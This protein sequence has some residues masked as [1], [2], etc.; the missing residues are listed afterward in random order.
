MI[1]DSRRSN[2]LSSSPFRLACAIA[3]LL[4]CCSMAR[5]FERYPIPRDT[6]IV[7]ESGYCERECPIYRVIVFGDG[8][9][10]WQGRHNV[11]VKGL[12]KGSLTPDQVREI[13]DELRAVDFF[14]IQNTFG[15]KGKGCTTEHPGMLEFTTSFS[16][17]S[18]GQSHALEHFSGCSGDA[19]AKL[20]ALE[21]KLK[22]IVG[23]SRWI[24]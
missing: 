14:H 15:F 16:I 11:R 23:V 24:K 8:D 2:V 10:I 4:L 7:M 12:A 13:L 21:T 5:G 3:V 22:Q 1:D 6:V 19:P 18:G 20:T 9:V 17:T